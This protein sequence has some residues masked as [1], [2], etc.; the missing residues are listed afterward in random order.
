MT[1][2]RCGLN[3]DDGNGDGECGAYAVGTAQSNKLPD[4]QV[5]VSGRVT[6]VGVE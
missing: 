6:L 4:K 1:F 2:G 3:D 5:V